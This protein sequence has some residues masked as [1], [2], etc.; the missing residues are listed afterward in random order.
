MDVCVGGVPGPYAGD[1]FSSPLTTQGKLCRVP[2]SSSDVFCNVGV[3]VPTRP[4]ANRRTNSAVTVC[5][6]TRSNCTRQVTQDSLRIV[7]LGSGVS[8]F[9]RAGEASDGPRSP[10]TEGV[11]STTGSL[12]LG[13]VGTHDRSSDRNTQKQNE[14]LRI[15]LCLATHLCLSVILYLTHTK[16]FAPRARHRPWETR[17]R[18]R[19]R[20]RTPS[21]VSAG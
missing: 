20:Q 17:V 21:P 5:R 1:A 12:R 10:W 15:F 7:H 3:S 19:T 8:P 6:L 11:P 14:I 2:P 9:A 13:W 18:R 16:R 4:E